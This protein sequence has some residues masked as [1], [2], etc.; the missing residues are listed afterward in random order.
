MGEKRKQTIA[1]KLE[2]AAEGMWMP[3][4]SVL[5]AMMDNR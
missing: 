1:E 4:C 3:L 5:S 2:R